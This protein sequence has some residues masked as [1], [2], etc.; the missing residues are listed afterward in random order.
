[1]CGSKKEDLLFSYPRKTTIFTNETAPIIRAGEYTKG[2]YQKLSTSRVSHE[3]TNCEEKESS[4]RVWDSWPDHVEKILV[5]MITKVFFGQ[6]CKLFCCKLS[7]FVVSSGHVTTW[8]LNILM[9]SCGLTKVNRYA[10]FL[11]A[12][13]EI[14]YPENMPGVFFASKQNTLVF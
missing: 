2:F 1:M 12:N 13:V 14:R 4:L 7:P 3:Y 6:S 10:K 9:T 11:E 5:I 8:G